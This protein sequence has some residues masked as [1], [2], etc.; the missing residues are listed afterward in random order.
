MGSPEHEEKE[1]MN[2]GHPLDEETVSN[3]DADLEEEL[4]DEEDVSYL[5]ARGHD[6][7]IG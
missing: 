6:G 5:A 3:V 1:T 7:I 2:Q 4:Q